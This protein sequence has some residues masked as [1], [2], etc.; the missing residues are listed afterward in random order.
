MYLEEKFILKAGFPKD[1][2]ALFAEFSWQNP[3]L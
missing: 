2:I 3:Q 1:W